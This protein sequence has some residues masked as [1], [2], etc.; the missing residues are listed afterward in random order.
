MRNDTTYS[1]NKIN[2]EDI[3][4]FNI[5]ALKSR[6]ANFAKESLLQLIWY[7]NTHTLKMVCEITNGLVI[8]TKTK[9]KIV[10][11][12]YVTK[13]IGQNHIIEHFTKHTKNVFSNLY[14]ISYCPRLTSHLDTK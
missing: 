10:E 1:S 2:Q 11:L 13:Y 5:F 9:Q 3:S 8:Y 6:A 7:T 14:L 12:T 4:I